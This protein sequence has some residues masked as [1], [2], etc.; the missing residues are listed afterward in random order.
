M[1]NRTE[2]PSFNNF[3]NFDHSYDLIPE[4]SYKMLLEN[5][6]LKKHI[7]FREYLS[8]YINITQEITISDSILNGNRLPVNEYKCVHI[9]RD[10]KLISIDQPFIPENLNQRIDS[11]ENTHY[12]FISDDIVPSSVTNKKNCSVFTLPNLTNLEALILDLYVLV[13]STEVISVIYWDGW[14]SFSY[15]LSRT[16]NIKLTSYVPM[17]SRY[18]NV[19]K[20]VGLT[21]LYNWDVIHIQ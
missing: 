10:D 16:K 13:N 19:C 15:V 7:S 21:K 2:L 20:Y 12:L 3:K 14:S 4:S 6:M 5:Y 18:Q 11:D 8:I 17:Y 9:R 1:E